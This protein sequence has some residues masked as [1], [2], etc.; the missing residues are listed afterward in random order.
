MRKRSPEAI[1]R[2][3]EILREMLHEATIGLEAAGMTYV[4]SYPREHIEQRRLWD[5][6][7]DTR[8]LTGRLMGDPIP[9]RSALARGH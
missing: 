2:N 1:K 5:A 9:E 7:D 8:S 6:Y 3:A 4:V